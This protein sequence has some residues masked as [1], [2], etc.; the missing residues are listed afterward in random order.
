M[1]NIKND[2]E[3]ELSKEQQ[4]NKD[5]EKDLVHKNELIIEYKTNNNKYL[6]QNQ[7]ILNINHTLCNK[8]GNTI[9]NN[10]NNYTNNFNIPMLTSDKL[11]Q[12]IDSVNIYECNDISGYCK[13]LAI[14]G[15]EDYAFATDQARKNLIMNIDGKELKD[16][17]AVY[18]S[19]QIASHPNSQNKKE[20][21]KKVCIRTKKCL[22][23]SR[24]IFR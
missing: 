5:L 19:E 12:F 21:I 20:E 24:I 3:K 14:K 11:G 8:V 2:Y 18:L 22:K 17:K 9:N 23:I 1:N 10:N 6:D 13:Q 16:K 7:T 15:V 4:K